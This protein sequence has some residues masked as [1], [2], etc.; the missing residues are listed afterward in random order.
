MRLNRHGIGSYLFLSPDLSLAIATV[1]ILHCVVPGS[2]YGWGWAARDTS[3]SPSENPTIYLGDSTNFYWYVNYTG[4]GATYKKAGAGTSNTQGG[5]NWQDVVWD[6]DAGDGYG[7]NEGI[8]SASVKGTSA[9]TWYYSLWLGWGASVGDNGMYYNGNSTWTEGSSS[10]LSSSFTVNAL[11]NPTV[12]SVATNPAAATSEIKLAWAQDGQSHAVMIVRK[13]SST[14]SWTEPTQGTPYAANDTLEGGTV[15]YVGTATAYTNTGLAPDTSYDYKLYSTNASYYSA[16]VTANGTITMATEPTTAPS[17][18]TFS[19]VAT[20][21]MTV[22]WTRGNGSNILLVCRAGSTPSSGP[23]DLT[24]Y[25]ASSTYGSGTALGGGF[26]VYSGSGTNVTVGSL[27]ASNTYYFSAYEYNGTN[28]TNYL[29]TALSGSKTTLSM[30]PTS[31]PA[32]TSFTSVGATSM[33]VNWSGGNGDKV[34]VLMRADNDVDNDPVDGTSYTA[35]S[36]FGAGS[37]I[38]ASNRVVF[39]GTDTSVAVSG[40]APGHTYYLKAYALKGAGGTENYLTTSPGTSNQTTQLVAPTIP[41]SNI[42]FSAVGA[43]RMDVGWTT[44]EAASQ[45]VVAREGAAVSWSPADN[46]GY[47]ANNSYSAASDQGAGNKV[48]Y[49]GPAN[50]FTLSGLNSATD[51]HVKVF[52]FYGSGA[53]SVYLTTGAPASNQTTLATE[54]G[55]AASSLTFTSVTKTGFTIGWSNGGGASRLVVVKQ[56]GAVDALPA[57][58]TGYTANS[59]FGSGSQ[60]GTGNYVVYAGSDS[61]ATVSGLSLNTSY[62]VAVVEF[63]GSSGTENYKTDSTLTGSQATLDNEPVI[64]RSPASFTLTSMVGTSP[65]SQ[66]FTVTNSGGSL[67]AY[68]VTTNAPWLS[69]S[70]ASGANL[71][72][73]AGI[74][75]TV[76]FTVT[77]LDACTSNATITITSTGSGT[78]AAANSPQTIAVSLT[79]TNIPGVTAASAMA[80]GNELVRLA[81]TKNPSFNVMIVYRS[82]SAPS[83]PTQGS[84]YSVGAA[85]GGGTVIYSGSGSTLEHVVPAGTAANYAFYSINNNHY[86][87]VQSASVTLGSYLGGEIVE[88]FAYTNP[89]ALGGLNGGS[90]FS[91]AWSVGAGTWTVETNY[92]S[93]TAPLFPTMADYPSNAANRIKTS[94]ASS[95]E[96]RA[97]RRFPAVTSGKL[98]V[99]YL[100][101]VGYGGDGKYTGLRLTTNGTEVVFFGEGGGMNLLAID[102]WGGTRQDSAFTINPVESSTGNVYLVVGRYDFATR[103][104]DTKAYYRTTPVDTSEP[105]SWDATVTLGENRA[106]AID[107]LELVSGGF[108][109]GYPGDTYFDEVRVATSWKSLL[110]L[111][112]SSTPALGCGPATLSFTTDRGGTP[113]SQSLNVTN[114]GGGTLYY[115]NTLSWDAGASGWLVISPANTNLAMEAFCANVAS[116]VAS[117]LEPATYHATNTLTGNQTNGAA[118]VTITYTVNELPQPTGLSASGINPRSVT[119]N[120]TGAGFDVMVVRRQGAAPDAPVQGTAYAHNATYGNGSQVVY[121]RG[122]GTSDTDTD[123]LPQTIYY[124]SLFSENYSR[125]SPAATLCVTTTAAKIDGVADEWIGLAPTVVGSS[126]ASS[127]EFIWRDKDYEERTDPS[128]TDEVNADMQEFRIRS[129]ASNLYFYVKLQDI[130]D[131]ALPYI[132]VGIDTDQSPTDDAMNWIG[133]ETGTTLGGGYISNGVAALHYAERNMI[134]HTVNGVG[135]VIELNAGASWY[136]PPTLGQGANYVNTTDN[137][138]E[139][140]VAR[141]DLGLS[142]VATARFTVATFINAA[143]GGWAN[144]VDTTVDYSTCDAVDSLSIA[145]IGSS[146]ASGALNS[147]GADLSDGDVDFFFDARLDNSGLV[148]NQPPQAPAAGSL[149]PATNSIIEKGS[150]TFSWGVAADPDGAVNSFF[151]ESCTNEQFNGSENVPI[152]YRANTT[153]SNRSFAVD[154]PGS[155]QY[156]WRVRS[157]DLSGALSGYTCGM[158]QLGLDDDDTAGPQP[159]LVFIGANYSP[160]QTQTNITDADLSNTNNLADIVIQWTDPSG[161]FLTNGAGHANNNILQANGRIIPNWDLYTTNGVTHDT[162]SFGYDRPFNEF[163]GY[164]G[165]TTVTT[166]YQNAFAITNIDTN[167][168]FFLTV[169]AED[170]DNDRGTYPDPQGDGDPVPWDRS[171]TVNAMVHFHVTDDDSDGPEFTH[172]NVDGTTFYNTQLAGGLTVTGLVQD[173]GSGVAG[174][175]NRFVLYRGANELASGAFAIQPVVDGAAKSSPEPV[176]VTLPLSAIGATGTYRLVVS[177]WDVDNDKAHDQALGTSEFVFQ[178]IPPPDYRYKMPISLNY[179]R[180]E[181]LTNF[182]VLVVL[183]ASLPG[184]RYDQFASSS[185]ADLRFTDASGQNWLNFEIETWNTNGDSCVWVQVPQLSAT[186]RAIYAYWGG[187][188]ETN[189]P[190]CTTNGTTWTEAYRGV[191][192]LQA[193]SGTT[194]TDSTA[195][196]QHG[197]L[198]NMASSDWTPGLVGNA[199]SFDGIDGMVSNSLAA[200]WTGP[201]TVTF[202]ARAATTGQ[203]AGT[204]LFNSGD[205]GF[206]IGP[207]GATPGDYRYAGGTTIPLGPVTTGWVFVAVTCD[208]SETRTYCNGIYAGSASEARN[209]FARYDIG[210]DTNRSAS[211]SGQVDELQIAN[212]ARSSNW[213][214]AMW[215]NVSSNSTFATFGTPQTRGTLFQIDADTAA[216]GTS[217]PFTESF[218]SLAAG[219]L[220]GRSNWTASAGV[221]VQSDMAFG[222]TRAARLVNGSA[223]HGLQAPAGTNVWFDWYAQPVRRSAEPQYVSDLN[224]NTTAAFY[225]NTNGQVVARSNTAWMT[226]PAVTVASN[227]WT[228]FTLHLDYL[229]HTWSLQ[230]A[231]STPNAMAV[232]VASN[233]P[234]QAATA[235]NAVSF[236]MAEQAPGGISYLD[237]L[238]VAAVAPLSVDEDQNG[239]PDAWEHAYFTSNG[240]APN[241]DSDLDGIDNLHERVAGTDPTNSQSTLRIIGMDL[242]SASSSSLVIRILGGGHNGA[243]PYTNAGDRVV[244]TFTVHRA[245]NDVTQPKLAMSGVLDDSS[246]TNTWTDP[247]GA[248][249]EGSRYYSVAVTL[250]GSGYTNTEEWAAHVQARRANEQFLITVPADC[251]SAAANN[252][253]S[254]LGQQLATGLHAG[255]TAADADRLRRWDDSG[256]W[257]EYY[258]FT[259]GQGG[260]YWSTDLGGA[261]TANLQVACGTAFWVIRG[262]NTAARPTSVFTGRS[263]TTQTLSDITFKTNG[264]GWTMFGWTLPQPGYHRNLGASTP[265]DQLGFATLGTGGKSSDR[266]GHPAEVG[267]QIWVWETNTW[268][269]WYWLMGNLGTS[270]DGRWWD[271]NYTGTGVWHFANFALQVG[272]AYYYWHPSNGGA[273]NFAWRPQLP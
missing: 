248:A 265:A 122:S 4:W 242:P 158:F 209:T 24:G 133:D 67:L 236:R 100:M 204:G 161:V 228:R 216:P 240:V 156:Y 130:T 201:F 132:A 32:V 183:N 8:R 89:A 267:D 20:S 88:P 87:P 12:S 96:W 108:S 177:G 91:G 45:L 258:L 272:K 11:N 105:A 79:L 85:C 119:L 74:G 226:F 255:E 6:N 142:G 241:A 175:S 81:W 2:A 221:S 18:M 251:G 131:V 148:A 25:T 257:A 154:S 17:T 55:A 266:I 23:V 107:G 115:T 162:V 10:F 245:I 203:A 234:F 120:W 259:N 195:Y 166:V 206:Q 174:H 38:G 51:Y 104:F 92:G 65:S 217:L 237:D 196:A 111:A 232:M 214:W 7:N 181:P 170:E 118:T 64:L 57:D 165:D 172:F 76:A 134:V 254:T 138:I 63:N 62:S 149:F 135:T 185:G 69:V 113:A 102:G 207:D 218:E 144:D 114:T 127:N 262:S 129:D 210:T 141:S 71:S 90:G 110:N 231:D 155:T 270:Y 42:V 59:V 151:L 34:I 44:G 83:D 30:E 202:W 260:C 82:G 250:A 15:V 124:Y 66:A 43:D 143:P 97:S 273:T 249:A 187:P 167:N 58:G 244:R 215:M 147:W 36:S 33:T 68:S 184:F 191:F 121:A 205:T 125:Y 180:S 169:S 41:S 246:G 252:L 39:L 116:L 271:D 223:W 128:G 230:V 136:A 224:W 199:L 5:M 233:L 72:T 256:N 48:V 197:T 137:F 239:L 213:V 200:G 78:N 47:T 227:A 53:S 95:D 140:S 52:E 109:G 235:T 269:R 173:V 186:T 219:S 13:L 73:S 3:R 208:G 40:L 22:G 229:S 243:S 160:G 126:T 70:P 211:F 157:R 188:A 94:H 152:N 179:D 28:A 117:N 19:G 54:P 168:I 212:A 101:A 84:S 193:T 139:W 60:L 103:Q 182:P 261:T 14:A 98:Y 153:A 253:N 145:A 146:D 29:S 192:H 178:V 80:D 37:L 194:A 176:A 264:G 61:S 99:S 247:D 190:A 189:P 238:T 225:I 198:V 268:T 86:S 163:Y 27:S 106:N 16:G 9:G 220:D 1:T 26:V 21:G 150:F 31:N 49:S 112:P 171:L 159:Q 35:S 56:G 50:S 222:G 164:N 263:F 123:V 75:H 77:G 93:A 46:T